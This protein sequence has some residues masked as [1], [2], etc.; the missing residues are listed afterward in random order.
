MTV[1]DMQGVET[2]ISNIHAEYI[3]CNLLLFRYE[4]EDIIFVLTKN[5]S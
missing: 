2:I 4:S 1:A 3:L 5:K